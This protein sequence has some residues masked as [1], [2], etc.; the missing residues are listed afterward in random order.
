MIFTVYLS[1]T[2]DSRLLE[3]CILAT[4]FSPTLV[5]RAPSFRTG[6][7]IIDFWGLGFDAAEKMEILPAFA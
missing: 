5:E 1:Q 3:E 4:F 6:D 7:Y 2:D